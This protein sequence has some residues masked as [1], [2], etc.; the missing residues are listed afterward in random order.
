MHAAPY[1]RFAEFACLVLLVYEQSAP[2]RYFYPAFHGR[3]TN[4]IVS[5]DEHSNDIYLATTAGDRIP[6]E[7]ALS[8]PAAS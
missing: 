5:F 8:R 6:S 7:R 4:V 3:N 2:A 1:Q